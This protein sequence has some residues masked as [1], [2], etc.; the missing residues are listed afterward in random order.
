[1]LEQLTDL[2][3][4]NHLQ[5]QALFGDEKVNELDHWTDESGITHIHVFDTGGE[6][7]LVDD[8]WIERAPF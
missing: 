2:F 8:Q 7:E 5:S 6:Y 1:M 3:V 4:Q